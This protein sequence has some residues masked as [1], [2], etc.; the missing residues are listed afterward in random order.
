MGL[1][2]SI[3]NKIE[4]ILPGQAKEF[5]EGQGKD[6][7]IKFIMDKVQDGKQSEAKAVVTDSLEKHEKGALDSAGVQGLIQKV[8]ALVKPEYVDEVKNFITN[9]LNKGK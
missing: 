8:S 9:F 3:K 7:I 5:L 2:D 1:F 4:D 6:Q